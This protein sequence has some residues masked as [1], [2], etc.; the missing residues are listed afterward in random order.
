LKPGI[1]AYNASEHTLSTV[2][3]QLKTALG[4]VLSGQHFINELP[5]GLFITC[6]F[7]KLWW[8]YEHSRA[9]RMAYVEAGHISQTYQLVAT[10]MG[11]S[12]WLTGALTDNQVESLLGFEENNPEQVLFFVGCGKSDG[13]VICRELKSLLNNRG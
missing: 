1:Y 4:Q 9:Y 12:T 2:N 3:T 13:Q 5:A 6:R 8:K 7:D 11:L 10:A